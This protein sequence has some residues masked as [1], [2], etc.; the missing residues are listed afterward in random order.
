MVSIKLKLNESRIRKD[1]TYPL[2]FQIIYQRQKKLI[3]TDYKLRTENFDSSA[4][5]V[6][7]SENY[8]SSTKEVLRINKNLKKQYKKILSQVEE[9]QSIREEFTVGDIVTRYFREP[10]ILKL[11]AFFDECIK[12]KEN[13][14]KE[15]IAAAYKSTKSSLRKYLNHTDICMGRVDRKFV[16]GYDAYLAKTDISE[17]TIKY[18]MRNFRSVYN[19]AVRDGHSFKHNYPFQNLHAS[20]TKTVKRALSDEELRLL[21][22]AKLPVGSDSEKY[23][24]FFFFSFFAQGMAFVDITRLKKDNIKNEILTYNRYKSKQIVQVKIT[25]H[26]QSLI[27]KYQTDNEYI[28]NMIDESLE[29]SVYSQYRVALAKSN[30]CLKKIGKT[31]GLS[32]P[33]TTYVARHTWAMGAKNSGAPLLVISESMGHKSQNTTLIYLKELDVNILDIVNRKVSNIVFVK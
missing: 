9:L 10:D 32:L 2:V 12:R 16:E 26:M 13:I 4:G 24:D 28:F 3:Y 22:R 14:K 23:R 29:A 15:G 8:L 1:G 19:T 21:Y 20:P 5:V 6:I 30:R 31:L 33:L 17:N 11:L 18:Y 7:C 27:D 25:E